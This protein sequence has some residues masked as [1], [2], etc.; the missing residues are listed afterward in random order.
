M[1]VYQHVLWKGFREQRRCIGEQEKLGLPG[2]SESN[3]PRRGTP[4]VS[5]VPLSLCFGISRQK[6]ERFGPLDRTYP[7]KE[8]RVASGE[9][10]RGS[11]SVGLVDDCMY[12][13]ADGECRERR[14]DGSAQSRERPRETTMR[15]RNLR[16][17]LR[18]DPA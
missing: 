9:H 18:W 14:R 13:T 12:E 2:G 11:V 15:F 6:K 4:S 7:R 8:W 10:V 5:E 1:S 17:Q 3:S 16:H